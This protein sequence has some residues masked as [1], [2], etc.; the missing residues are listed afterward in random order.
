M[1]RARAGLALLALLCAG[2]A[3]VPTPNRVVSGRPAERAQ[4]VDEPYVRLIAVGPGKDWMPQQIVQGF[5]IASGSF[6]NQHRIAREYLA[7]GVNWNPDPNPTVA[8]YSDQKG[9]RFPGSD[10]GGKS[11]SIEVSVDRLGSITSDGQYTAETTQKSINVSFQ[12]QKNAQGQWRITAL[13]PILDQGLLLSRN[14]RDRTFRTRNLYYFAPDGKVLV[15]NLIFLPLVNRSDLPSQLVRAEI[16]GPTA[17]LKGAVVSAFP[18]GTKLLAGVD[19]SADGVATVNLSREATTGN[20][21]G[22]AA[23]L[24][25]ALKQLAEIKRLRLEVNG[26]TVYQTREGW[27][28]YSP[29]GNPAEVSQTS[30]Y[31]DSAGHLMER[32]ASQKG[33]RVEALANTRIYDPAVS[34][35]QYGLVAGLSADA[36][37]VITAD[38]R[39]ANSARTILTAGPGATFCQPSWDRHG[40]L[41]IVESTATTSVL[42][43][44]EPKKDPVKVT[45]WDLAGSQVT[46]F[47]VALDGVRVAAIARNQYSG[48]QITQV[49]MGRI[50]RDRLGQPQ[51]E[52]FLPISSDFSDV[53]DLAWGSADDLVV[54][55]RQQKATSTQPYDL[56]MSGQFSLIGIAALN[57]SRTI[58]AGPGLPILIGARN[59]GQDVLCS[60][61]N[62]TDPYSEWD[63]SS[64]GEGADPTYPG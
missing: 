22:M 37:K 39:Q 57:D 36:K 33:I 23:Q 5:L 41:W 4:Q 15:P 49:M 26:R 60:F 18:A 55:A 12:L 59:N 64:L 32:I 51:L 38:P 2:C 1:M 7:P 8:V 58:T 20:A 61:V 30:Y 29:D 21:T 50:S 24:F 46:A 40:N 9:L 44:K 25:W 42:W 28:P 27:A 47:R 63:C 53:T 19:V 34:L 56:P 35:D 52:N 13:P 54:L 17:W 6:D 3:S 10:E 62:T 45:A 48:S 16:N 31:R 43:F 14:D 11:T